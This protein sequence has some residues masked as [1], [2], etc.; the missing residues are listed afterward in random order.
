MSLLRGRRLVITSGPTHGLIDAIRFVSNTSSGELG[1]RIAEAALAQGAEVHMI[2]GPGSMEPE[3]HA[4]L[5]L[6]PVRTVGDVLEAVTRILAAGSTDAIVHAMAVLDY[7]PETTADEKI[8]SGRESIELRLVPTPKVID[9]I[10]ELAP[11]ALLVGFK[12]LAGA[13]QGELRRA[14]LALMQ[15]SGAD[16]VVANDLTDIQHGEHTAV[17]IQPDGRELGPHRGKRGIAE[18]LAREIACRLAAREGSGS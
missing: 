15:R 6:A 13:E 4:K 11:K 3:A 16:L 17:F 1:T 9:A 12:L 14:A 2:H 18:A 8:P 5:R 7:E 10:R